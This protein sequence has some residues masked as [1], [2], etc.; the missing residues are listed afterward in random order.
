MAEAVESEIGSPLSSISKEELG[1]PV[2]D[3]K[4][5]DGTKPVS[6][7]NF[8]S[9]VNSGFR[10][11]KGYPQAHILVA[12]WTEDKFDFDYNATLKNFVELVREKGWE[13]LSEKEKDVLIGRFHKVGAHREFS[14]N[15][16]DALELIWEQIVE[17]FFDDPYEDGVW[18]YI[19]K[20]D[21]SLKE[22]DLQ[23]L[24]SEALKLIKETTGGI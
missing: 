24:D 7:D 21:V 10:I 18:D 9:W 12:K 13:F 14:A 6:R 1:L 11:S 5:F 22:L 16:N 19:Q 17:T 2:D 23:Q 20:H 8:A 15:I 3:P 4:I